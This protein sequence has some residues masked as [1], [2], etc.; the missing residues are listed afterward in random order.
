MSTQHRYYKKTIPSKGD[1]VVVSVYKVS[2][3][4]AR[5][6]LLEYNNIE[7]MITLTEIS[8][9]RIRSLKGVIS[10]GEVMPALV[11]RMDNE[12]IDLSKN[13]VSNNEYDSAMKLYHQRKHVHNLIN[14]VASCASYP[15]DALYTEFIWKN[16][17]PHLTL[18][19][20]VGCNDD[21]AS[22]LMDNY[23]I[24]AEIKKDIIKES[25]ERFKVKNKTIFAHVDVTCFTVYGIDA[26]K[27]A[28]LAGINTSVDVPIKINLVTSPKYTIKCECINESRGIDIITGA[29]SKIREIIRNYGGDCRI[30]KDPQVLADYKEGNDTT[31]NSDDD[32]DDSDDSDNLSDSDGDIYA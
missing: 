21:E 3:I 29:I 9:K 22:N 32:L 6:K 24:P 25:R 8:R 31:N 13:K 23:D 5:V 1:I 20:I 14:H 16:D 18:N 12:Y 7:G 28:L 27:E 26:I 17:D 11:I 30:V 15:L 4:G 19:K 10:V 2:D